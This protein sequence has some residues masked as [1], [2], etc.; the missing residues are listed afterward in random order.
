MAATDRPHAMITGASSGI[1]AAFAARLASGGYDLTLVAR[2]RVGPGAPP[3]RGTGDHRPR[4]D[5]VPVPRPGRDDRR[6]RARAPDQPP[7]LPRRRAVVL[8]GPDGRR[9]RAALPGHPGTSRTA[10]A[11]ADGNGRTVTAPARPGT[12]TEMIFSRT[13]WVGSLWLGSTPGRMTPSAGLRPPE[14]P[15]PEVR[16]P[17]EPPEEA[18]KGGQIR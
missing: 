13:D 15:R 9:L 6:G 14:S 12:I 18:G 5:R 8:S 11:R 10:D 4:P 16:Q 2:R 3:R 17:L 1:G 7:A